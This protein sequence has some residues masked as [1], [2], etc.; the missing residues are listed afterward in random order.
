[1]DFKIPIFGI[2][3]DQSAKKLQSTPKKTNENLYPLSFFNGFEK[4]ST[5]PD[6]S[7]RLLKLLKMHESMFSGQLKDRS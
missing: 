2:W 1:M 7:L 3:S 6:L 5:M 4:N